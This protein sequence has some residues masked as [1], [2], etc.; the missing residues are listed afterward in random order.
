[1]KIYMREGEGERERKREGRRGRLIEREREE[2]RR[3]EREIGGP[4]ENDKASIRV[5][6]C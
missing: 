3:D 2:K 4:C 6:K 1:M 5:D